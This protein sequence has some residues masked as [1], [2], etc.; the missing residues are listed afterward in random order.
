MFGKGKKKKR[1]N[2][3]VDI[4][5]NDAN[6]L[7]ETLKLKGYLVALSKHKTECLL[8]GIQSFLISGFKQ[9]Y[10]L[11]LE[12]IP[13]YQKKIMSFV[14]RE[15]YNAITK[16]LNDTYVEYREIAVKIQFSS[17]N[18]QRT[19]LEEFAKQTIIYMGIANTFET[20]E[21][22]VSYIALLYRNME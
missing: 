18:W 14:D 22:V 7:L 6:D 19:M 11:A 2:E 8:L 3:I 20:V 10:D 9:D 12:L 1:A 5:V 4:V 16:Y 15:E 17:E 21:T 13:A